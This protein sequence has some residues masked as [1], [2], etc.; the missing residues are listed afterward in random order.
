MM[1]SDLDGFQWP[2]PTIQVLKS[3]ADETKTVGTWLAELKQ[4]TSAVCLPSFV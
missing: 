4:S 1:R 2:P 3:E